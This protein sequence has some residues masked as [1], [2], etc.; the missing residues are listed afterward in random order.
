MDRV[1]YFFAALTVIGLAV[2]FGTGLWSLWLWL[3]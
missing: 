2:L 1:E 3:S